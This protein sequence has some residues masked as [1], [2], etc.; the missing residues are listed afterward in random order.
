MPIVGT[1]H[2]SRLRKDR[3]IMETLRRYFGPQVAAPIRANEKL[4]EAPGHQKSIY[5]Y[6]PRSSGAR[7]YARLVERIALESEK[8]QNGYVH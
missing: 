7:D 6:A 2:Q 5:E 1:Y 3:E 4:A 8:I